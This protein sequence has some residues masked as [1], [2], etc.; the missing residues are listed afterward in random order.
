M[1]HILIFRQFGATRQAYAM[2]TE[3]NTLDLNK[4]SEEAFLLHLKIVQIL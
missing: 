2:P 1:A 3:Q 4:K